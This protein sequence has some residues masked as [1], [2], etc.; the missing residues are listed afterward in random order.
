VQAE[1]EKDSLEALS[2]T[3]KPELWRVRWC[4][5]DRPRALA[6]LLQCVR[7]WEPADVAEAHA[8]LREWR[9]LSSTDALELFDARYADPAVRAYA[10]ERL[11]T[12]SDG[13]LVDLL[14]QLVQVIKY[15]PYH[16]SP[17]AR[18]LVHRA[19]QAK[20]IVGY[21][22]FWHLRSEAHVPEISQRFLLLTETYLRGCGRVYR[23]TLVDQV[24]L[25][26]DVND[27]GSRLVAQPAR[28]ARA[29][30]RCRSSTCASR[31]LLAAAV[32][33][34]RVQ[35]ARARQVPLHEVEEDAALADVCQRRRQRQSGDGDCSRS[36]TTCGRTC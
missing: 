5:R 28:R 33:R 10:V 19:L 12:L 27:V 22:L 9:P 3:I 1:I 6:K 21:P 26:S 20:D 29:T 32:H 24:R 16:D 4:L 7:W 2:E 36:A 25:L 11:F 30:C 23:N 8:L 18:F 31:A 13:A 15:E 17:L 14:L 35:R 34:L